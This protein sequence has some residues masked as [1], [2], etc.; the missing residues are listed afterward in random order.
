M[1][2]YATE[3]AIQI[4]NWFYYNLH[5]SQLHVIITLL[6]ICTAYNPHTPIFHS[7]CSESLEFA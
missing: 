2:C 3:D 1:A 7:I 4:V 5:Q 6:H